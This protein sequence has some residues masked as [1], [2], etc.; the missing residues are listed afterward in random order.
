MIPR[1]PL[2]IGLASYLATTIAFRVHAAGSGA[3]PFA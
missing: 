3:G 1:R 2:A